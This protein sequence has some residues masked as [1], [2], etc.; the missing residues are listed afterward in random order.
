MAATLDQL[1]KQITSE[2]DSN[3]P[4][5]ITR[6]KV[7]GIDEIFIN[8]AQVIRTRSNKIGHN[9]RGKRTVNVVQQNEEVLTVQP[10]S[11]VRVSYCD[12]AATSFVFRVVFRDQSLC[13]SLDRKPKHRPV[14]Q[15]KISTYMGRAAK[16]RW[17]SESTSN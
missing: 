3:P 8:N 12:I 16:V 15:L 1:D 17:T 9:A 13:L 6:R 14:V 10:L 4:L 7:N 11:R 2:F 5:Y